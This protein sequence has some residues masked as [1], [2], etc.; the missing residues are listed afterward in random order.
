MVEFY[1]FSTSWGYKSF[2]WFSSEFCLEA[3]RIVA[4]VQNVL[5]GKAYG[6]E[7]IQEFLQEK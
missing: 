6:R 5:L 4:I 3:I 7:I 1:I 2:Y